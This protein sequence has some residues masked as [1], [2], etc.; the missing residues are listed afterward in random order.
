MVFDPV[1]N[2]VG[3]YLVSHVCC[4]WAP[5]T[6]NALQIMPILCFR[7]EFRDPQP[8]PPRHPW[9]WMGEWKSQPPPPFLFSKRFLGG[10]PPSPVSP[11]GMENGSPSDG[12]ADALP[13]P[14]PPLFLARSLDDPLSPVV[15]E[16]MDGCPPP[17]HRLL[18]LRPPHPEVCFTTPPT[19]PRG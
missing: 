17:P 9:F 6:E 7:H 1:L 14:L 12:W 18:T 4:L 19:A 5:M 10:Y 8:Q 3:P 15:G 2:E 16:L 13:P 11:A